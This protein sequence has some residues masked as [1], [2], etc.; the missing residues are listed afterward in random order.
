MYSLESLTTSSAEAISPSSRRQTLHFTHFYMTGNRPLSP[1]T[2]GKTLLSEFD[3]RP[4]NTLSKVGVFSPLTTKQRPAWS[5]DTM[6]VCIQAAVSLSINSMGIGSWCQRLCS[7]QS[8]CFCEYTR[9]RRGLSHSETS[10]QTQREMFCSCCIHRLLFLFYL[11]VSLGE[12][13]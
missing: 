8:M 6:S 12:A 1:K 2:R 10:K 11:P 13:Q 4:W 5:V 7:H 3:L 9:G